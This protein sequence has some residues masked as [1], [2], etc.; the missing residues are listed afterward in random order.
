M[1]EKIISQIK[2]NL[3]GNPDLDRDYLVSQL[4]YYKNHENAYEIIKE[5]SGLIWQ[6]LDFYIDDDDFK[7]KNT[8]VSRILYEVIQLIENRDKKTALEKLDNFMSHFEDNMKMRKFI[9]K[10]ISNQIGQSLKFNI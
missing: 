2:R 3:S 4:D 8:N 7:S 6:S 5:I 10:A 9:R 1:T